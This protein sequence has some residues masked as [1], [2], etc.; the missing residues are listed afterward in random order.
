MGVITIRRSGERDREALGK[1]AAL[2]SRREP[3]GES[4][5]AF[6]GGDLVAALPLAGGEALADPFQHTA[7]VIDLLRLRAAQAEM[8][9]SPR[10][11]RHLRRLG[12][13]EG[14]AA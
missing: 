13:A 5:L 1:L 9:A 6:D 3:Q 10:R 7:E 2:D 8:P 12:L 14:R 4:L 11:R